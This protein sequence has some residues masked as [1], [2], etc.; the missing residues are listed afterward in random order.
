MQIMR[1]QKD[2]VKIFFKKKRKEYDLLVQS[3]TLLLADAF[4]NFRNVF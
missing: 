3:G 2:F 1:M 4:K